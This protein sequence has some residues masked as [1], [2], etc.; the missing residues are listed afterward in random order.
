[1]GTIELSILLITLG[2][3]FIPAEIFLPSGGVLTLLAFGCIIGGISI[4]FSESTAWG[5]GVLGGAVV[6]AP[7]VF[8]VSL[9]IFPKT[10]LGRR[11]LGLDSEMSPEALKSGAP[12]SQA[13]A[14][15]VGRVGI[16]ETP[17]YPGGV[18]QIDH[19][20]YD[21]V[22]RGQMVEANQAVTVIE[23]SGNRMVVAAV[24]SPPSTPAVPTESTGNPAQL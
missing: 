21:V 20:R 1:M 23:I 11:L 12:Q 4:G 16:T 14:H 8:L 15:L 9:K 3:F 17:L 19:E 13:F 5:V 2:L 18:I 7:T 6:L 22:T 24:E 10:A